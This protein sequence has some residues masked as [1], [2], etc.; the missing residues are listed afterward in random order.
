MGA[1]PMIPSRGIPPFR[2]PRQRLATRASSLVATAASRPFFQ[3]CR[4]KFN[5][6]AFTTEQPHR[7]G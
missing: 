2:G 1:P 7:V 3:P 4:R 6:V 5:L